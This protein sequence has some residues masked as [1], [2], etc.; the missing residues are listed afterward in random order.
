[1]STVK[2]S[3]RPTPLRINDLRVPELPDFVLGLFAA[4]AQTPVDLCI[5]SVQH[6]VEDQTGL[7][8]YQDPG[9]LERMGVLLEA[10]AADSDLSPF[11]RLN[12]YNIMVRYAA[13]RSRLEDL[14]VKH[15]EI[16]QTEI[17][18]PI[19]IA[20]LPRSGTTH[21]LNLISV[22]RRLRSLPYWES[23]E[24]FPANASPCEFNPDDPRV[25][26][27]REQLSVQDVIMPLFKNM[28]DMSPQHTH[29]EIELMG[30]DFSMMLF[31]N[32]ALMPE[33]RDYFVSHDQIE[34]YRF[35]K[36][37]LKALQWLRGPERWIMKSPQ[38]LEQLPQLLKVFPDASFVLTHRDPVS[39]TVSLLTM[40]SYS[41]RLSRDPVRPDDIAQYWVDRVERMLQGCVNG[42]DCLP[43]ERTSQV[44]FHEFMANDVATVERIYD[45]AGHPMTRE[46]RAAMQGYMRDN[47]RGKYGQIEYDLMG[48]FGLESAALYERYGFY[49]N[50][51]GVRLENR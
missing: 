32:Y 21:L 14:Y 42:V 46:I 44:L 11:G 48:D 50:R 47:P 19:I 9:Y 45:R 2:M 49:T 26:Q 8:A 38:H 23:I 33:W 6:A 10:M 7:T 3:K 43:Q 27:C 51:F 28:H 36:R 1:M 40:L 12:N 37:C 31:E 41:A 18:Q 5:S 39:V 34:H 15:P 30:L 4:A 22:D 17:R 25:L 35:L 20:G 16:E 13:Q 24:P 29:E